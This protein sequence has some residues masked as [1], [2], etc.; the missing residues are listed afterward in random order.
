MIT[1]KIIYSLFFL[2]FF[3]IMLNGILAYTL[4]ISL[5]NPPTINESCINYTSISPVTNAPVNGIMYW[6]DG[7]LYLTNETPINYT[8]NNNYNVTN[9]TFQITNITTYNLSNG[10]SL[11][12]IQNITANDSIIQNWVNSKLSN[13]TVYNRSD[14]NTTFAF[15]TELTDLINTLSS[16]ATKNDLTNFDAKYGYLL[17]INSSGINGTINLNETGNEEFSLTWK[18]IVIIDCILTI[19]L[20]IF[21]VRSMMSG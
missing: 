15:R 1:K 12:I 13:I 4:Q 3:L 20:I 5:C 21:I 17:A 19:I 7:Y 14:A 6:K 2:A 11:T 16:Y 8:I 10:S 9:I 18:V